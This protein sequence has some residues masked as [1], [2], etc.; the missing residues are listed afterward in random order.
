[1]A[2]RAWLELVATLFAGEQTR[3][4][5]RHNNVAAAGKAELEKHACLPVAALNYSMDESRVGHE[6][7]LPALN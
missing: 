5:G 1:M 6:K 7:L 2:S 4:D 3:R